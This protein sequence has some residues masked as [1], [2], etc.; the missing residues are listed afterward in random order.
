M[1]KGKKTLHKPLTTIRSISTTN[2]E[3]SKYNY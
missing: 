2:S 3:L 1:K